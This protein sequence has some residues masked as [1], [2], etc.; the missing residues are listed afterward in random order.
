[1]RDNP[2]FAK[3]FI[4]RLCHSGFCASA[5]RSFTV[6]LNND[7]TARPDRN[8]KK[9]PLVF[10]GLAF[11]EAATGAI[12]FTGRNLLSG[13]EPSFAVCYAE[14][15]LLVTL[16]KVADPDPGELM[17]VFD[18]NKDAIYEAASTK[19]DRG[20]RRPRVA[21]RDVIL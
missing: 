16:C 17:R 1:M 6:T 7:E 4:E 13:G 2:P 18:K 19:F 12:R 11:H 21:T 8:R 14:R 3:G 10:N 5:I 20:D 9:M 15:E